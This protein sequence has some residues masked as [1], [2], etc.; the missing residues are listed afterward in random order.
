[1]ATI[2]DS[3]GVPSDPR[4]STDGLNLIR[5]M[6]SEASRA[7]G[8]LESV[9]RTIESQ[10][11]R[12]LVA[13]LSARS[14]W[15]ESFEIVLSRI[16][17]SD[18]EGCW[19]ALLNDEIVGLAV[20]IRRANFWGLS[21]LYVAPTWRG[22]GVGRML[23]DAC[24]DYSE[25]S[26]YG[27]IVSSPD[28]RAMYRYLKLG[29]IPRPSVSAIGSLRRQKFVSHSA[30]RSAG[31]S[32][33]DLVEWIDLQVRGVSRASDIKSLMETGAELLILDTRSERGYVVHRHGEPIMDANS[34]ILGATS[35]SAC[36]ALL[37]ES[38]GRLKTIAMHGLTSQQGWA[39][40]I[41]SE[42]GLDV[43][44]VGP[45]FT[46]GFD[47]VPATWLVSGVFF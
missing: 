4:P 13:R 43:R 2:S 39:I 20:S 3:N 14:T 17:K 47:G 5:L 45:V 23:V 11:A 38:L 7:T 18:P 44:P 34:I 10:S 41:A 35:Q 27:M 1:M 37:W 9:W 16:C 12:D 33:L 32:S 42:A 6:P 36:Q 46:R 8:F 21:F 29:F 28:P 26:D 15:R 25:N 30:V 31:D 19:L 40:D 22:R 24:A